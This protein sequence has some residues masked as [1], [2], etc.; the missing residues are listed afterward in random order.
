MPGLGSLV[1]SEPR[2]CWLR[3][4]YRGYPSTR[5]LVWGLQVQHHLCWNSLHIPKLVWLYSLLPTQT[6][7]LHSG[8][9][10]PLLFINHHAARICRYCVVRK[11]PSKQRLQ[12][13]GVLR[14]SSLNLSLLGVGVCCWFVSRSGHELGHFR[15]ELWLYQQ[16][17]ASPVVNVIRKLLLCCSHKQV[18]L[19]G[20]ASAWESLWLPNSG[21]F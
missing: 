16:P 6:R 12:T 10:A 7:Q 19:L 8:G 11:P 13:L 2:S 14:D 20:S 1:F 18:D 17:V 4:E 5:A 9:A 15:S 21:N 3:L